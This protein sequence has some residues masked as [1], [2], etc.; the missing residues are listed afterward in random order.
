[1]KVMAPR[2]SDHVMLWLKGEEQKLTKKS[3]FKFL[4]SVTTMENFTEVVSNNRRES[5]TGSPM[6]VLWKKLRSMSKPLSRIK[7]KLEKVRFELL[8]AWNILIHDKM[9]TKKIERVK[10][11]R[12]EI[13]K[14]NEIEEQT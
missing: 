10:T 13:I 11:C 7:T 3:S 1:M 4:N 9:N 14:W 2:V 8:E 6:Y 12:K 5:M